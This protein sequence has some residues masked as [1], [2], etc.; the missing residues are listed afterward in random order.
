MTSFP[1][2]TDDKLLAAVRQVLDGLKKTPDGE[3]LYSFIERGLRKFGA[4]RIETAFLTFVYKLLQRYLDGPD[5]DPVTRIKIKI[6]Q[7]RLR[8]YLAQVLTPV[9]AAP[10]QTVT[11]RAPTAVRVEPAAEIKPPPASA[12]PE[13][14][15]AP[16]AP[17]VV[18]VERNSGDPVPD[19]L[20]VDVTDALTHSRDFDALLRTSLRVLEESGEAPDAELTQ[21]LRSGLE[22]LIAEHHTLEEKL[23]DTRRGLH[24]MADDRRQM[25]KA[26]KHARKN[27]LTDELTG[28]AN[29]SAFLRQLNAEIGRAR[30]YGFSL[31]LVLIDLDDLN[32]VNERH[33]YAAGDAMLR[34]YANEIMSQFRSYDLVARTGDDEFGVLLPNTQK[35]GA[36]R[37]IDKA[38]TRA[39]GTTIQFNGQNIPLLSFS[40]VL[41]LYSQGEQPAALLRRVDDALRHAKQR[42]RAQSV[43]ALAAN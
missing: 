17:V 34:I 21:L 1:T 43:V 33:G 35:D 7:Q 16:A 8:P 41:T 27:S 13:I 42:G 40:S 38:Q 39:A 29:R 26:L 2:A 11:A 18:V 22:E 14:I 12:P 15:R 9:A 3:V 6:I 23:K 25:E 24:V 4:S 30:R 36:Q 32:A 19:Q 10:A 37:A 20:A 28:L 5:S 31:A